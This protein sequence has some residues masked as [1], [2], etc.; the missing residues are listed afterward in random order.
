MPFHYPS[1]CSELDCPLCSDLSLQT[2]ADVLTR[3]KEGNGIR[4]SNLA[5]KAGDGEGGVKKHVAQVFNMD[6]L[7]FCYITL[8]SSLENKRKGKYLEGEQTFLKQNYRCSS[9]DKEKCPA[10]LPCEIWF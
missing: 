6:H 4:N 8:I 2:T 5:A 9:K 1:E 3:L 10:R 7:F